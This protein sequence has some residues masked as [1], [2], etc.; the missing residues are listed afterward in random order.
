MKTD[1]VPANYIVG[2]LSAHRLSM[3]RY[4]VKQVDVFTDKPLAGNPLAVVLDAQALTR[5]E[6][7]KIAKEFNLSETTF[8]LPPTKP[9]ADYRVR[10]FTPS[11]ELP[12]AGHPSIGT[13]YVLAEEGVLRLRGRLTTV[14]QQLE[15]GVLPLDIHRRGGRIERVVMEQAKP[16]FGRLF[17]DLRRIAAAAG[18]AARD[19]EETGLSPQ[20]VSTGIN[21]LMVPVRTLKAVEQS[22]PDLGLLNALEREFGFYG[23]SL[24]T[25]ETLTA[26]ASVHVRY[27][28]PEVGVS[29]D[30]ATG[31]AAGGLGAYLVRWNILSGDRAASFVIEQGYEIGRPSRIYVEVKIVNRAPVRVRVGGETV[32]VMEGV[33]T[34][35]S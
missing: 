6:M 34:L 7:Q 13:A 2:S 18:V 8:V 22:R 29:E 9:N 21:Q 3:R 17:K 12:F 1:G 23:C 24:F 31:S 30:P 33:I 11:M 35:P 16:R 27:Y 20:L 5:E 25:R 10:I 28:S 19:I 32:P 4:R 14:H 26:E 15:I